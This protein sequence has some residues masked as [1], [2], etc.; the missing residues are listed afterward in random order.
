MITDSF[1][2]DRY[3]FFIVE[4]NSSARNHLVVRDTESGEMVCGCVSYLI[5]KTCKHI[6]EVNE[7]E[8][9]S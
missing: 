4:S 2:G 6:I 8:K 9:L 5:R 1:I 7:I 3:N